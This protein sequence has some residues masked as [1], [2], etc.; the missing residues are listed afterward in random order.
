MQT[1]SHLLNLTNAPDEWVAHMLLLRI[2]WIPSPLLT[3]T[4]FCPFACC[5]H[6]QFAGTTG[7][8]G[9][10]EEEINTIWQHE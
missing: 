1:T 4:W 2:T 9:D 10:R 6:P 5:A 7:M 3:W 8:L